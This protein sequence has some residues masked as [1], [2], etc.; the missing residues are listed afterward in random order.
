M[1]FA[2]SFYLA[3]SLPNVFHIAKNY[4]FTYCLLH[5]HIKTFIDLKK[6]FDM[7]PREVIWWTVCELGVEEWQ[8]RL[9]LVCIGDLLLV[10]SLWCWNKMSLVM[11]LCWE[12]GWEV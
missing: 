5:N 11:I 3:I 6:A 2:L 4:T 7:I 9:K 1:L 10:L 12:Y 8:L